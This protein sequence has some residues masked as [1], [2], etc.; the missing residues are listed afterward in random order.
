MRTPLTPKS[1]EIIAY[2]GGGKP[3][4]FQKPPEWYEAEMGKAFG[5][6][7]RTMDESGVTFVMFAH[8]TTAAWETLISALFVEQTH[9]NG[10]RGL[11]HQNEWHGWLRKGQHLLRGAFR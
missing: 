6:M 3:E 7:R 5:E 2:Y 9:R 8:K 10:V 4:H 1:A 11:F